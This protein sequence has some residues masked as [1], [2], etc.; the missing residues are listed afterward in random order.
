MQCRAPDMQRLQQVREVRR[1]ARF[2]AKYDRR[3]GLF[4]FFFL[5]DR[6]F[7]V[8]A[9]RFG[10]VFLLLTL[11]GFVR[12]WFGRGASEVDYGLGWIAE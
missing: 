11:L 4:D 8:L 7:L 9:F 6:W 10:G 12:R 1:C 5:A 3:W 2:R